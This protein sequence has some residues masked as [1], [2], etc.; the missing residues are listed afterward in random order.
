V[1]VDGVPFPTYDDYQKQFNSLETK[2]GRF[3]KNFEDEDM[4]VMF[5]DH[6]QVVCHRDGSIDIEEY[7]HD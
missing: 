7:E 2:V 6:V 1:T 3:M 5:G 4:E